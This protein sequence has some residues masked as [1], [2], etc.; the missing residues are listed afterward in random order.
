MSKAG[1]PIFGGIF[2]AFPAVFISILIISYRSGGMTFS[3]AMTK[4]LMITGMLT[5]VAYGVAVKFFYPELGIVLG[6]I[7]AYAIS[8]LM[9]FFSYLIFQ[10]NR[11]RE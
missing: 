10:K 9:A 11:I 3:R 7:G 5:V 1:D 6:T 2:S 4:P 8:L